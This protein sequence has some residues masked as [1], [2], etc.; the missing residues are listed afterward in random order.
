MSE[1][2]VFAAE[3]AVA[4][5]KCA[6]ERY[7]ME[8]VH[9]IIESLK[10]TLYGKPWYGKAI[11]SILRETDP[12]NAYH[13]KDPAFPT[14]TE[15]L[16]HMVNWASFTLSCLVI[17]TPEQ[18]RQYE[19]TDWRRVNPETDSWERAF[20]EFIT[21]H[22]LIVEVLRLKNNQFLVEAVEARTYNMGYL[23]SGLV[24]HNIYHAGQIA[25][26]NKKNPPVPQA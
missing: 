25:L 2:G 24:H 10:D 22:H 11:V 14:P 26:M 21:I 12:G 19:A 7:T 9:D 20:D 13:R 8:E 17:N 15:L 6:D 16:Y 1:N 3:I 5:Q 4:N 18:A 23:L